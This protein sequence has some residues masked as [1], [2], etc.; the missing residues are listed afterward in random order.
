MAEGRGRFAYAF[1][2]T[3]DTYATAVL[4]LLRRLRDLGGGQA[5]DLVVLHLRVSPYLLA[6]MREMGAVT[7]PAPPAIQAR[8]YHKH[9]LAK[10]GVFGLDEYER[11][12]YM[13]ADAMLLRSLDFLFTFPLEGPVAAAAAYWLPQPFWSTHLLVIEP[14]VDLW[15]R[16]IRRAGAASASP[17]YDMDIVNV[18]LGGEIQTLPAGITCLDSEWEDTR[19]PG[20]FP[21]A[22]GCFSTVSLVHFAALGKPWSYS[23]TRGRRLRPHAYAAFHELRGRWWKTR[24][25]VF[26]D[27]PPLV[28]AR[29]RVSRS[30][31]Q[32]AGLLRL[33][34]GTRRTTAP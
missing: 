9:S 8:G 7:R 26:E 22:A 6:T 28:A 5:A 21:D 12:V 4:V 25:A 14:S 34:A 27:S 18:E 33:A 1:Y 29:Y 3:N 13:D 19:R 17:L 11:V 24:D 2:A 20:F 31:C 16:V 15:R 32:C 30:W 10:L 23:V